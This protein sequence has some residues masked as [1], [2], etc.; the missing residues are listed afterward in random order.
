MR[1]SMKQHS[2]GQGGFFTGRIV[3]QACENIDS[4][5]KGKSKRRGN[6]RTEK[7]DSAFRFVYDCGSSR[8][9]KK[10]EKE[11]DSAFKKD[12][13][14]DLLF[15]SHFDNDHVN[16][17]KHLL[18]RC[19]VETVVLPYLENY[20]KI[21]FTAKAILGASKDQARF[22]VDLIWDAEKLLR[23][24]GNGIKKL[25]RIRYRNE[26]EADLTKK[27]PTDDLKFDNL[28][29]IFEE[30]NIEND[31]WE[32]RKH[33]QIKTSYRKAT[34]KPKSKKV[35]V[36]DVTADQAESMIWYIDDM[37]TKK[38]FLLIP[39]VHPYCSVCLKEFSSDLKETIKRHYK[40][41]STNSQ[42]LVD[43]GKYIID[44]IECKKFR[45]KLKK[46]YNTI[47]PDHNLISMT[48]YAG[49][50]ELDTKFFLTGR[51]V[52]HC[53]QNGGFLL[54]GDASFSDSHNFKVGIC[55]RCGIGFSDERRRD[56]FL[57][58]YRECR[59]L[60]GAFMVPHHGSNYNF[61]FSAIEPFT[62]LVTSYAAVGPNEYNHPGF[63]TRLEAS[64][65]PKA[66]FETV[67]T[68]SLL[69]MQITSIENY[70]DLMECLQEFLG[71]SPKTP[72]HHASELGIHA[73]VTNLLELGADVEA[74]DAYGITP[75]HYAAMSGSST[76][77]D[78]V[79][80]TLEKIRNKIGKRISVN[81]LDVYKRRPLHFAATSGDQSCID[82]LLKHKAWL[83][84]EDSYGRT[85]LH[86][87]AMSKN[88]ANISVLI[89]DKNHV[90]K[91][92][93]NGMTALHYAVE[94]KNANSVL[95][96]IRS[97]ADVSVTNSVNQSPLYSAFWDENITFIKE[98]I[99]VGVDPEFIAL[100]YDTYEELE[101]FN[102]ALSVK[103][104]REAIR[105]A[106]A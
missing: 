12:E 28:K 15:I 70:N 8:N 14:I 76:C 54:T 43:Y 64:R 27:E 34:R 25:V 99:N 13:C 40:N 88:L 18:N 26:G 35:K 77:L 73:A 5:N 59:D 96:L 87:A 4:G 97:E 51:S 19:N 55:G 10:L 74:R 3:Y 56:R 84:V 23:E 36:Y 17:L 62:E 6:S 37:L 102:P 78:A 48:L 95:A 82:L 94:C 79:I 66:K 29:D 81:V 100:A 32:K 67:E 61:D 69:A 44:N 72:L 98:L 93:K 63:W 101:G 2:V 71:K 83:R 52:F 90:N 39:H 58:K 45:T 47:C 21:L 89:K 50:E 103:I 33:L 31:R 24:T 16:G 104:V 20:E 60:V 9:I 80:R 53:I 41:S 38:R 85:P 57:E 75:L 68:I 106:S 86:Y 46:K 91:K 22:A 65:H 49:P 7:L 30:H 1:V 42:P 11:I 105:K 92:D